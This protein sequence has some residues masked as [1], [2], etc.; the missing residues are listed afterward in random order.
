MS[1]CLLA[2]S[3]RRLVRMEGTH[4]SYPNDR[5]NNFSPSQTVSWKTSWEK[6]HLVEK[7]IIHSSLCNV[8]MNKWRG[9]TMSLQTDEQ[10]H[11][12][13]IHSP[14]PTHKH[15]DCLF[16]HFST[17]TDKRTNRPMDGLTDKASHRVQSWNERETVL[18]GCTIITWDISKFK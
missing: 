13:P 8:L 15:L 10:G 2:M 17:R 3:V 16:F 5:I 18:P 7:T 9:V 4:R 14:T 11:P 1:I 12:T 6:S